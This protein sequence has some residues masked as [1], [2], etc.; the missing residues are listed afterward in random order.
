MLE[1][2][3][4]GKDGKYTE[5]TVGIN[6]DT[7][8]YGQNVSAWMKQT[9]EQRAAKEK[10]NYI[11]NGRVFHTNNNELHLAKRKEEEAGLDF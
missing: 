6:D 4:K 2:S 5:I 9:D 11:G 10:R 3:L 1:L 7:N 8:E